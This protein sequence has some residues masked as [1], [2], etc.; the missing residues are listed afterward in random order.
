MRLRRLFR[1]KRQIPC[2]RECRGDRRKP[3][4]RANIRMCQ[5]TVIHRGKTGGNGKLI[6]VNIAGRDCMRP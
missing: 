4:A 6:E 1:R 3:K 2:H 5:N